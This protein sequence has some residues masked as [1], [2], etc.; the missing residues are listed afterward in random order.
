MNQRRFIA[1]II[2]TYRH[3]RNNFNSTFMYVMLKY[4]NAVQ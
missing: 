1:V 2:S 3:Y 4:F